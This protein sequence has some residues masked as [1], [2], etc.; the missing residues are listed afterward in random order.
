M[1]PTSATRPTMLQRRSSPSGG[2][3]GRGG[4]RRVVGLQ[5]GHVVI[6][7]MI[8]SAAVARPAV[9]L[10]DVLGRVGA[11]SIMPVENRFQNLG[12]RQPR[13]A[14]V[15]ERGHR[16]LVGGV[17]PGRRRVTDAAGL[18]GQAQ[19]REGVEVGRL[20]VEPAQ[21]GPVDAPER[22]ADAVGIGER[23][24][25]RQAHVGQRELGDGGA[26]G[27]LHHRVDDRLRVHDHLDAVV[28]DAEQ[29]VGLD[30]LEA[31]VHQRRRVDGDLRTHA[32][33]R[34]GQGVVD[35]DAGRGRDGCGRGTVRR[36][37]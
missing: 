9:G 12:D 7:P 10:D 17:E 16:D 21:L 33:R 25:D 30:H 6:F 26:V 27:E 15:E 1:P 36:W 19:A 2:S 13:D 24:P 22:R 5:I 3:G 28:A 34:M 35:G 29:L 32:P 8:S 23:V 31:L 20:E 11:R 14:A 37:R 18:V 4:G